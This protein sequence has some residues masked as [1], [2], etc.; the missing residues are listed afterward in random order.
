MYIT[1]APKLSSLKTINYKIPGV[2]LLLFMEETVSP[3]LLSKQVP[4]YF[5]DVNICYIISD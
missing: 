4:L 3:E 1:F 2:I 5:G